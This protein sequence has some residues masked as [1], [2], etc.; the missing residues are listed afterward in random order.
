[1]KLEDF[2]PHSLGQAATMLGA[3]IDLCGL[4]G[5]AKE[6]AEFHYT[7]LHKLNDIV[8]QERKNFGST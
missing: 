4:T 2:P 3:L 1:M 5:D 7:Q 8:E 6:A